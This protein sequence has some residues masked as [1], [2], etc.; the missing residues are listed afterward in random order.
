MKTIRLEI[1]KLRNEEHIQLMT[2]VKELIEASTAKTLNIE[3]LFGSF[4]K[5]LA[6]EGD[7]LNKINKSSIT[8]EL[9]EADGKRDELLRGLKKTTQGYLNHFQEA[10]HKAAIKILI[11]LDHY[12]GIETKPYEQETSSVNALILEINSSCSA[13]VVTLDLTEWIT[14]LKSANDQFDA[15]LKTRYDE[16]AAKCTLEMKLVRIDIDKVYRSI[17][18]RTDAL[19]LINGDAVYAP[20]VTALNVRLDYF[21]IVLLQRKARNAKPE[22]KA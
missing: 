21:G 22:E 14:E 4:T 1:G 17:L 19:M 16:S 5:L 8:G 13:E 18:D 9:S 11:V 3:E 20:F 12:N 7:A 10:K 15:L 2:E 6:Q